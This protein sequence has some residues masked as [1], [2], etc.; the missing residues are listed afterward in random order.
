VSLDDVN[1]LAVDA[2]TRLHS[3]SHQEIVAGATTDVYFLRTLEVLRALGLADTPVVAEIFTSRAG[4]LAG[5]DEARY[6]LKSTGVRVE[7]LPEGN[8]F[9][10]HEVVMRIEGPYARFGMY[11]TVVLGMLAHAS[12]WATAAREVAAAAG[13]A[14]V[15]SFG[16]RHVHPAV[17]PVMERAAIIGGM[18]GAACILGARLAGQEPVGTMPHAFVLLVGDTLRA[19]LAYHELT[20]PGVPRLVLVD[21]FTDEAVEAVQVADGMRGALSAIRL[22]TPRERGSVTP[23]LVREVRAR[24]ALAGHPTV[25]IFVSGGITPER[26]PALL[27]AGTDAFGVGSYVS[28][29]PP[30]DMTMDLREINGA[31]I[32]KRGRIPGRTAAPRLQA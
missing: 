26:I 13:D 29:A 24:L 28:G 10:S 12:G 22:D 1:R 15:Y 17:A 19:A 7:V 8:L 31:P 11:E 20:P 23:D 2:R 14:P 9:S 25:Q 30:I 32:A 27:D 3:A 18:R 5:G 16:A 21:T 6:L 4:V